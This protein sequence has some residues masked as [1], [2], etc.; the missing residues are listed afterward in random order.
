[1][2]KVS[3]D[4]ELKE[5]IAA[6]M[7]ELGTIA[8]CKEGDY[9]TEIFMNQG[10]NGYYPCSIDHMIKCLEDACDDADR[11]PSNADKIRELDKGS[12]SS[13]YEHRFF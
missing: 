4:Q 10:K 9:Q 7:V 2:Q 1:M 11:E 12:R 8:I 6:A 3:E 13:I 5:E